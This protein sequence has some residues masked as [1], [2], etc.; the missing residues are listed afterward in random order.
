VAAGYSP[1]FA[2]RFQ[3][4][5]RVAA[6]DMDGDAF[7]DLA[8]APGATPPRTTTDFGR[9]TRLISLFSGAATPAWSAVTVDVSAVFPESATQGFFVALGNVAADGTGSGVRELVVASGLRV[10]VFDVVVSAGVPSIVS[11]PVRVIDLPAPGRVT[12]VATGALFDPNGL[13]DVVVATT[14]GTQRVAGT[15]TVTVLG[16]GDLPM[17][18]SFRVSSLVESGPAR[19]LVD[20]F[21]RGA[22]LAVGD[23]D[24]DGRRDLVLGA[25]S[26]GLGNF[27]VLA[28]EFVT[29]PTATSNRA[30]FAAAINGQLG[31]SSRFRHTRSAGPKWKPRVGPDFFTPGDVVGPTGSGFNAPLA[32]ATVSGDSTTGG[33]ARIFAALG[34][35]NQ[36]ANEVRRLLYAAPGKWTSDAAFSQLPTAQSGESAGRFRSGTGLRLG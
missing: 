36:T 6:G 26:N 7:P 18:R 8:V 35:T 22:S 2:T 5:L 13:D 25:G 20:V 14:T 12:A 29:A 27:R 1:A 4:G 33:K 16:G 28:N 9:S 10:A 30:A 19:R 34:A 23:V 17:L 31:N 11:V 24:G 21:G 15:T 3:G 32:V